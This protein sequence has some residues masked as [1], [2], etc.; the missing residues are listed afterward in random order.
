MK[1]HFLLVLCC[2]CAVVVT[3]A[4]FSRYIVRLTNKG[5]SPFSFSNPSAYL[6]DRAINRRSRFSIS[7]DSTD[8]PVTPNYIAQIAAVPQVTVLAS[9]RWL[10]AVAIQT[11]SSSAL[12]SISSLP[13]VQSVTGVAA[14]L[15]RPDRVDYESGYLPSR[16]PARVEGNYYDYGT[17][18]FT[19]I[20]LHQGEFL[21]NIGLRGQGM[22]IAMLD[23]GFFA[24][25]SL[26]A[27]DSVNNDHRV[28][29]T[30]DVIAGNS[31]VTEDDSHGMMCFS[32]I[33]ANIPGQFVGKAPKASFHLFRTE[34]VGSEYVIEEFNWVVGAE[35]A[36]SVGADLISSS[37]GYTTFDAPAFDHPYSDRDGNTA[38]STIGADLAAQKGLLVF[39]SVGNI[40]DAGSQFLSVPSDGDSVVAVGSVSPSGVV[41]GSSS[42][43]PSADG[44]IKP[45]MASVG[46]PAVVQLTNNTIGV[47]A[48]TSFACPN[49]AGLA[50]CLWQGFPEFN[51]MK[52]VRALQQAG[53]IATAPDNRTGY[54]IPDMKK[55]FS[56]LLNNYATSSATFAGCQVTVSW[57]TK[58]VG[59]MKFE[60][61]RR[62]PADAAFS[63]VGELAP[64]AGAVLANHSY[65]FVNTITNGQTGAFQYR[66]RQIIDT[67]AA[68]FSATYI[69]TTTV[70]VNAGCFPTGTT[71]PT[72]TGYQLLIQPNPSQGAS[73]TLLVETPSAIAKLLIIVYDT[74]GARISSIT[75]SK[76][77]GR[78]TFPL[79]LERLAKGKYYVH[80]LNDQRELGT[81]EMIRL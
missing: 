17:S 52:I 4:Q 65:Q 56:I 62:G 66:I 10:N 70:T 33:A 81:V 80:V 48:G 73:T 21:H 47:S 1:K 40:T 3:R 49:M 35:R 54:G 36:D 41:A 18:S 61:E 79:S 51:N 28:L 76:P 2:L 50:T 45:D 43:G 30:W 63:K 55:A 59:A 38:M 78:S 57:N 39:N 42:Y 23:A 68:S 69:D 20:H 9:S 7:I 29:T 60:I 37:L 34:D 53:N 44:R 12:N 22:Q 72:T 31:S 77:A 67:A 74:R 16:R 6:S 5:N 27:F 25:T 46:A 71:D 8:L 64:T 58:D 14:R 26:K 19:E 11:T 75:T 24:Y 15:R 13:F 32:T